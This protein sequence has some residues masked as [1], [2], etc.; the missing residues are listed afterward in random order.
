[1][2]KAWTLGRLCLVKGLE[3]SVMLVTG[4]LVLDVV[5]G[6]VTR[7]F[8]G[9][10]SEIT[11]ELARMLLIWVS[12]LGASLAFEKKSHLGVDYFVGKLRDKEKLAAET[13]AYLIVAA[14]SAS[15]IIYGGTVLAQKAFAT[16]QIL[17]ALRINMGYVYLALPISGSFIV[18]FSL[19]VVVKNCI[20]LFG[21]KKDPAPSESIA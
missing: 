21:K 4:F 5:W 13:V 6:F 11:S 1:M 20:K 15:V 12:L 3:W 18:L 10:Q 9:N 8:F 2:L 14:F 17:S 7:Y 19:E 16:D